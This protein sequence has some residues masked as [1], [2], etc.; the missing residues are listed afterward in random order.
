MLLRCRV[1]PS[2][3]FVGVAPVGWP[4]SI[5]TQELAVKGWDAPPGAWPGLDSNFTDRVRAVARTRAGLAFR[6]ALSQEMTR[7]RARARPWPMGPPALVRGEPAAHLRQFVAAYH[8]AI[9]TIVRQYPFDEQLQRFLTV[10]APLRDDLV[11]VQVPTTSKVH[12]CRLDLMLT[13]D[14]GYL[15]IETNANC[16]GALFSA[17]MGNRRWREYLQESD[18]DLPPPLDH[19][20]SDWTAH[21]FSHLARSES[22]DAP[23]WLPL[24]REQGGNRGE[25]PGLLEQLRNGGIDSIEADPRELTISS[26]GVPLLRGRSIRHAY[27]KLGIQAMA[28]MRPEL[29][30]LIGAVREGKIFIQNGIRGR[31]IGDN[32]L[33]LAVLSDPRFSYLLSRDDRNAIEGHIPWS[34]NAGW[35]SAKTLDRIRSNPAAYVLK[36][37]LR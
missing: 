19:E 7:R 36:P 5:Q 22:G 15:V 34:R 28:R 16:P 35:C 6:K 8:R 25:F 37:S 32:K 3:A 11:A 9:E 23:D 27:L 26:R 17:G 4:G 10:P 20:R 33:C 13:D 29:S 24:L 14:G 1:P 18:I 31:L 2:R 21:W 30:A 12:L